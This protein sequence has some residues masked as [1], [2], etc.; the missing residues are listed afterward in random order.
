[1]RLFKG[2]AP[3]NLSAGHIVHPIDPLNIKLNMI[4]PFDKGQ[5]S[6]GIVYFRE[7]EDL[8]IL[9]VFHCLQSKKSM[10]G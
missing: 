1:M 7:K 2:M 4:F 3:A 8:R 10:S 5:I 6:P 9:K